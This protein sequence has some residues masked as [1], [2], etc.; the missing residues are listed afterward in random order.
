MDEA[1][2]WSKLEWRICGEFA[3]MADGHMMNFW[4]D[5]MAPYAWYLE[6]STL[7]IAGIAWIASQCEYGE[8]EFTL[9]LPGPIASR[10]EINWETLLPAE[11]VTRWLAFDPEHKR[12]Q[13]ESGAGCAR[14]RVTRVRPPLQTVE[15]GV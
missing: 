11:N 12:I 3:G 13:I 10:E 5:G 6:D 4:C 15:A 8:W 9:F 2:F 7:R 1:S 14:S